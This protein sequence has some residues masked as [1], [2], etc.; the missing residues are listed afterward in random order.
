MHEYFGQD[1]K[2]CGTCVVRM[3]TF[4]WALLLLFV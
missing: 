2:S 1:H 3:I 4:D